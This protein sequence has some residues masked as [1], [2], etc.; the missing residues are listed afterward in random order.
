MRVFSVLS[1]LASVLV[2]IAATSSVQAARSVPVELTWEFELPGL[3][4]SSSPVIADI[5]SDGRNEI[6]FGHRDG[7]LRA[8]E[9]DGSLKWEAP[10][11]PGP[12]QES[13]QPQSRP[14]AIDSSPAVA[15]IDGDGVFEV[16]VGVGSA[17][18]TA[19]DQNGSVIAFD[20]RTGA[21]EW[22]FSQS[23]DIGS[24]WDGGTAVLDGWCEATYATPAIGDVDG[25]GA[26]DIVFASY[27][28]YIWAIDGHG[29]PLA[30]FPINSDDTIWSSAALFDLDDD[31]D[32]EIFIGGDS[33]PLGY[34]DHLGGIFRAIDYQDGRPVILWSRKAN[35]VFQSSPAIGDIN[36]D[37]RFEAVTG[38]GDKWHIECTQRGNQLCG[39]NDGSDHS[40]VWAFHLDDGTDV[41]GW[42]FRAADTVWSSPSLGDLDGDGLPEV[43]VGSDD[44]RVYALKGDGRLLWAATP[45]F[46]HLTPGI[47]RGS[48]VIADLDGDEDQDVAIGTARGLALL[49]GPT[50]AELEAGVFWRGRISFAFSHQSAPA[51]G[52]LEGGRHLVFVANFGNLTRTRVAA[53]PLPPTGSSDAW[54]MFRHSPTR[55]GT[56]SVSR[57]GHSDAAATGSAPFFARPLQWMV[58]DNIVDAGSGACNAPNSP[59]TRGE[60]ALYLWRLEG[61]PDAPSHPFT[62]VLDGELSRAVAWMR[63]GGITTGKSAT[64]FAPGDRL[65][66]AEVAAFL[67]RLENEPEASDHP[68]VDLTSTWQQEPVAWLS[69]SGITT[70]T[71]RTTFA[72]NSPVTRGQLATFLFRYKGSPRVEFDRTSN[73]CSPAPRSDSLDSAKW[74]AVAVGRKHT[75][76]LQVGG[77]IQCWGDNSLGQ[78]DAPEGHYEAISAGQDYTCGLQV[79]GTIQ[80]W[81]DNSLGQIGAPES[82]FRAI[83]AG[84]D[85]ACGLRLDSSIKCWGSNVGKKSTV[86]PGESKFMAV[87]V[88]ELNTCGLRLDSTVR[89]WGSSDL[90]EKTGPF[91]AV[92]VGWQRACGL[93]LD[94]TVECWG[95]VNNMDQL[96][97][98]QGEFVGVSSGRSYSCAVR[99]DGAVVC[100]GKN[101]HGQLDA[102]S[103]QFESVTT[104]YFQT[105]AVSS[106]ISCWGDTSY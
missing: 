30:G 2:G 105:C 102:P 43:V 32:V 4:L 18:P 11:V 72:P 15:D 94:R 8:Y 92:S 5:D 75:C 47:V 99:V 49:D 103:G 21:I 95:P 38:T 16:V 84:H 42:P 39:P 81:G 63:E 25:D 104:S 80:C 73:D 62:D 106:T 31:G 70:G 41:S 50:G 27:D 86:P 64:S 69:E 91:E 79:G 57:S 33:T 45:E 66:R 1:V 61:R 53:Y 71:S 87:S 28:F 59:A 93:R 17:S 7:K 12:S 89:C 37:G 20:G 65:T 14:S 76:G 96:N 26:V 19:R 22:S 48:A 98:P 44:T 58:G 90:S 10:A 34:V 9:A 101:S 52:E 56:A 85:S 78:I 40:K 67:H 60:T 36:G 35:E 24:I 13:C 46:A 54:P 74:T 23:R 55:V 82:R 100:W 97:I 29:S 51:V 68:F 77:A 88:G 83:S 6:V 3:N